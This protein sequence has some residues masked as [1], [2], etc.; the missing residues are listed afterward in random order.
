MN[1][2]QVRALVAAKWPEAMQ[3]PLAQAVGAFCA[4]DE[5]DRA[6]EYAGLQARATLANKCV[7]VEAMGHADACIA[8]CVGWTIE[9]LSHNVESAFGMDLDESECDAIAREAMRRAGLLR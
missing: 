5:A 4:A 9:T 1:A 8:S 2:D 7:Q 6:I 3:S